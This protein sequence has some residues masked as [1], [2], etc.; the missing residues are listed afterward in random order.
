MYELITALRN[1]THKLLYKNILQPVL[2]QI[3][4]EIIH[5]RMVTIGQF[6]GKF[7]VLRQITSLFFNYS[8]KNLEQEILGIK[9]NNPVG[10]GAG[11]DKNAQ[12]TQILPS[13]GF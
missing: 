1:R 13:L 7:Y 6:L 11:F 5:D 12:L 2:F 9:F 8:N 3:D 4:P 10:L